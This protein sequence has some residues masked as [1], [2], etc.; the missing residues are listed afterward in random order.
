MNAQVKLQNCFPSIHLFFALFI[1][2]LS[3]FLSLCSLVSSSLFHPIN[4]IHT[5]LITL[6]KVDFQLV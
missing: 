4:I 6:K 2:F 1:I 3:K 5:N